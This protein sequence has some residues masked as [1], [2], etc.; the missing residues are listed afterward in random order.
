MISSGLIQEIHIRIEQE[1]LVSQEKT[2]PKIRNGV[3]QGGLSPIRIL[4][5]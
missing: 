2:K 5:F 1:I 4:T 3:C